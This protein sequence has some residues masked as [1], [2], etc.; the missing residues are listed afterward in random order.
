MASDEVPTEVRTELR[1]AQSQLQDSADEK[2]KL[3]RDFK[4]AKDEVC[5]NCVYVPSVSL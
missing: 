5:S 4:S 2:A 1:K 3:Q